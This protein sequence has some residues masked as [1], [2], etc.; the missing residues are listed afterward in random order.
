MIILLE[1]TIQGV[2]GLLKLKRSNVMKILTVRS[3]FIGGLFLLISGC[4]STSTST[5]QVDSTSSAPGT[6]VTLRGEP[7]RLLGTPLEV[8]MP[9]P[10]TI[11][12]DAFT[13]KKVDLSQARDKVMLISLVPSID[14]KVCETQTHYLGEQGSRLPAAIER[15][16]ISRDTPFAQKRFSDEAKL[17]NITF[18]SDY[19]DGSFGK[20]TGLLIDD[21]MLLARAVIVVDEKGIVR[22]IQVV[23]E[24]S[25]LPDMET[26]FSKAA[27][28]LNKK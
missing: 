2:K 23:P 4:A 13:M 14:T 19:R 15:I 22:Y 11:L 6:S 8:G 24:L 10:A 20:A 26:A 7:Q 5:I 3:C 18:L 28:L 21:S 17:H 27:E 25:H 1:Y 16:T 12:T 9:L